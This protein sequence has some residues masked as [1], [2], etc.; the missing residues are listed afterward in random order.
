ML[1]LQAGSGLE[2]RGSSAPEVMT[3]A[4]SLMKRRLRPSMRSPE[5]RLLR[6]P[7]RAAAACCCCACRVQSVGLAD[8]WMPQSLPM[9]VASGHASCHAYMAVQDDQAPAPG[10]YACAQLDVLS[11][12]PWVFVAGCQTS[13]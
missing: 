5:T 6:L 8:A 4:V 13:M 3:Q 7:A 9:L 1:R 12:S 10:C 2:R 11:N